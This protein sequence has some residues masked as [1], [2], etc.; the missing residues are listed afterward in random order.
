MLKKKT[1]AGKTGRLRAQTRNL[2]YPNCLCLKNVVTCGTDHLPVWSRWSDL[3]CV[4]R[5]L[6]TGV[7]T[8]SGQDHTL[9]SYVHAG[10]FNAFLASCLHCRTPNTDRRGGG[11]RG[12]ERQKSWN[13]SA[14]LST[15]WWSLDRLPWIPPPT[16]TTPSFFVQLGQMALWTLLADVL[17]CSRKYVSW[18]HQWDYENPKVR[19][20]WKH[21]C[22][23]FILFACLGTSLHI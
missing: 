13:P 12:R 23:H 15:V 6:R 11:K 10:G 20:C 5:S 21:L 19:Q 16:T 3:K 14:I 18:R 9:S 17:M 7:N 1:S 2:L 8:R 4:I 22:E